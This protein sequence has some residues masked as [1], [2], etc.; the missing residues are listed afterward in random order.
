M[1]S[2][3]AFSLKG[4]RA[5]ITGGGS[6]L[7]LAIAESMVACGADVVLLGRNEEQLKDA[8]SRLGETHAH[9]YQYDV[10][11]LDKAE[12]MI[13]RITS[14]QGPITILCNNAGKHCKKTVE[15]MTMEDFQGVLDVHV[16]GSIALTKAVLPQMEDAGKGS[17]LFTAS[18]ASFI[19]IPLTLGY[20]ASKSA[21]L[22]IVRALATEVSPKGIRVN[23]IAPGWIETPLFRQ[24]V[25]NDPPRQQ[26]ILN[27][28][29]AGR[30]GK[31]E[32][33]GWVCTFLCSPA[34][35]FITGTC[36]P[37]DGGALIGF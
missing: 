36:L 17:I 2:S 10:T 20:S 6:G 35:G 30:F 32:E 22:G 33:I 7:G 14:L 28:T 8:C 25:D 11:E 31:P 29:P 3:E 5:V 18:M 26:K 13:Q 15:E 12:E 37:V 34:A 1:T 24:M 9:W 4:E 16:L 23:A 21:F 27:R 19:G